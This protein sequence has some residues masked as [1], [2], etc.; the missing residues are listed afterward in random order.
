MIANKS[1]EIINNDELMMT[2]RKVNPCY[3][4]KIQ[5]TVICQSDILTNDL[6]SDKVD[7]ACA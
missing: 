3:I 2:N 7:T 4:C 6:S 5:L 1:S